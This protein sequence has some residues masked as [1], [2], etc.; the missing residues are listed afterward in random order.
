MILKSHSVRRAHGDEL[1]LEVA[2]STVPWLP[3]H[4]AE[5][6]EALEAL[7]VELDRARPWS[8]FHGSESVGSRW[9]QPFFFSARTQQPL[10]RAPRHLDPEL[11]RQSFGDLTTTQPRLPSMQR[12][13]PGHG[14]VRQLP[15]PRAA[16]FAIGQ[17]RN[18][19]GLE[20]SQRRVVGLAREAER[21]G[22]P[23]PRSAPLRRGPAAS[24]TSPAPCPADRRT[25]GAGRAPLPRGRGGDAGLRLPGGI[26]VWGGAW[27]SGSSFAEPACRMRPE[28]STEIRRISFQPSWSQEDS[29]FRLFWLSIVRWSRISSIFCA[30]LIIKHTSLSDGHT[31][32]RETLGTHGFTVRQPPG[33]VRVGGDYKP[34]FTVRVCERSPLL[35]QI[36]TAGEPQ[37]PCFLA[38]L[39]ADDEELEQHVGTVS[40]ASDSLRSGRNQSCEKRS[41]SLDPFS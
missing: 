24:R 14:L 29:I 27:P 25:D 37:G 9:I 8:T 1:H 2:G 17:S 15:Q 5:K 3:V 10:D 16:G 30:T 7:Q 36:T 18:A 33:G 22:P 19:V 39:H 34:D 38:R 32:P 21:L 41:L 28:M 26:V 20:R 12:D 35:T 4:Q 31:S 6:A 40:H 11:L 23:T 13:H